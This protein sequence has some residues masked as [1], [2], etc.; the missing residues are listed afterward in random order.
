MKTL[1]LHFPHFVLEVNNKI[2]KE[3]YYQNV[4]NAELDIQNSRI[5]ID[6]MTIEIKYLSYYYYSIQLPSDKNQKS[7]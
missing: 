6:Q 3:D 7:R 2:I 4:E 5:Y 1:S